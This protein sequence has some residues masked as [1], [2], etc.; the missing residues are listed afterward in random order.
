MKEG[1]HEKKKE[2][3][4]GYH[5]KME[6]GAHD[7]MEEGAHDKDKMEEGHMSSPVMRK[8]LRGDDALAALEMSAKS[9]AI[10]LGETKS[11]A[12]ALSGVLIS[13]SSKEIFITLDIILSFYL[14]FMI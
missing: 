4:E 12:S 9:T 1:Y 11:V 8:G 13:P 14:I 7:K 6:E 3:E 2:M 10:G 5:D